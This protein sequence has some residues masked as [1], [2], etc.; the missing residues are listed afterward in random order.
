[1]QLIQR[2]LTFV[3]LFLFVSLA[4]AQT[5]VDPFALLPDFF[6]SDRSDNG[7]VFQDNKSHTYKIVNT[8]IEKGL[9]IKDEH[10]WLRHGV[11]Y[12]YT[13]GKINI[14]TTYNLGVREGE[15][16]EYY[17]NRSEKSSCFYKDNLKDGACIR[18]FENGRKEREG[19]YKM[20]VKHGKFIRYYDNGKKE[21][22]R[23]YENGQVTGVVYQWR[24]DGTLISD[25]RYD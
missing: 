12:N 22:D 25:N 14:K 5:S 19:T 3:T 2:T 24:R 21:S 9:L 16:C 11:V 13:A 10:D 8:T 20:G 18:Y 7:V 17:S 23:R 4:S 6:D 1:M 15:Q